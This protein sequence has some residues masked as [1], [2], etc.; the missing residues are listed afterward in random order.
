MKQTIVITVD[1]LS[2]ILGEYLVDNELLDIDNYDQNKLTIYFTQL[3][4]QFH[5]VVTDEDEKEA[6][7]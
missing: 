4:D 3:G 6:A 7:N 5:I 2:Q 1:E